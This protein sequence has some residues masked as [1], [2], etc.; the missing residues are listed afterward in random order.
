MMKKI[1]LII[2]VFTGILVTGCEDLLDTRNL[3]QKDLGN[4]Y[5]TPTDITEAMGGV[6]NAL[7]V[8]GVFSEEHL[9]ANLMSD[10]MLGGG[11]PDDISAK[12]CDRFLDPTEDTYRDLWRQTYNGVYRTNAII[13]AVTDADY[14]SY[15][16]TEAEALEFKNTALGEAYFMR[17]F[18]MYRAARFFGG[19]PI[20]PRTD[21]PRDVP[22]STLAET[23]GQIAADFIMAAETLPAIDPTAVPLAEYGHANRWVAKAYIA[24]AYM[25]YTG[26]MTN[27]E[28]T[29]TTELPLPDGSSLTKAEAIS[30]LDDVIANSKYELTPDFRNLW[31]YAYANTS[32]GSNILPWA[33][34]ENLSWVGQDGPNSTIGSGN[35]EVMFALRF[36]FG[37]WGWNEGQK[38][39]N[40]IPLFFGIR[41][42]SMVPFGEGWGWGPIHP[43]FFS[44]WPNEDP[45]KLASVLEMS[46]PEQGTGGY[47]PNKGDHETGLFNK[48]YSHMQH[49]GAN[50][51]KGM[52]Y[53]IYNW[54]NGDPMQLESAQD[55][56]YLRYADVLLMHSEL[57]ETAT[58]I[59][60]V[61]ARADLE[62]VAYSIE[63]LKKERLYELAFEGLRW[64]DLV[65]WGD[66]EKPDKNYFSV[67][68]NVMNSGVAAIYT[69][70]YRTE[71]KGLLPIP[72]SEI[73]LSNGVYTQNPGW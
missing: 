7:Y 63:N 57:T 31:P 71:I 8:G 55:F 37:N 49:N 35:K 47:Q 9:T 17:G 27:I 13:E 16:D 40:R 69:N 73:R 10:Y 33:T 23:F 5:K 18:F 59:N 54:N 29:A 62:P 14:S 65:R 61:R 20:I 60:A 24:R 66:V 21:S 2:V 52:F 45:R 51:V 4:F 68:C 39:N 56:F 50:G 43:I 3:Y 46:K 67:Q 42:N 12:N 41:G 1:L 6:Y 44:S 19:M 36:A 28:K 58:G 26:Y 22:R 70:T 11:G 53:Y 48:K 32:A 38:F 30:Q 25:F 72:E 34:T 64:F 15:F